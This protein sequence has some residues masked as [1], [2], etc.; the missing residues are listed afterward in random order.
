MRGK[1]VFKGW[2]SAADVRARPEALFVF[3]DN[4]LR[5]GFGGQAAAMRGKAN[6]IGIPTKWAPSNSRSSFFR[7]SDL[8]LVKAE[9]D[10]GFD[11]IEEALRVGGL[12]VWPRDGIGTGL[13]QLPKCAPVIHSYIT[14]RLA[15]L[16]DLADFVTE[17]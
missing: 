12:V 10:K 5:Q 17:D 8:P 2:I 16:A 7:D 6:S 13:A 15:A 9:I 1:I 11:S 14:D 3:G 4:M